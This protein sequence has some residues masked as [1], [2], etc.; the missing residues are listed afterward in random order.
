[1]NVKKNIRMWL[2]V[3]FLSFILI[4]PFLTPFQKYLSI[5]N[6][7]VTVSDQSTIEVP[8]LGDSVHI[9]TSK[10][11][12]FAIDS[13]EINANETGESEI[14]YELAGVP[15]KKVNI[16][17]LEDIKVIP[18]GQSIGVQL[19]TLGVLVVGHHLV[20]GEN[21]MLSPGEDAEVK[22]GDVIL[23]INENPIKKMEDV[24][25]II[26]EAGE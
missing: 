26:E 14:F 8:N 15:I 20:N 9:S 17:L 1:M 2:G 12:M 10:D 18:G 21:G 23:E 22:V 24:K 4:L 5:P 16:S 25:P 6:E 3:L 7:I 13:S 11:S 19:H